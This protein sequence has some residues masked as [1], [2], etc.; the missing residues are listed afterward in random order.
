MPLGD[1]EVE[2]SVEGDAVEP[3]VWVVTSKAMLVPK[4]A[5][6]LER[7]IFSAFVVPALEES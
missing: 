5:S 4:A 1:V 7:S 3:P 6:K 2:A